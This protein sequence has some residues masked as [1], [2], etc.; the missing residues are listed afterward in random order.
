M[1]N[2][3]IDKIKYLL[4]AASSDSNRILNLIPT[5]NEWSK[6]LEN[7]RY[8]IMNSDGLALQEVG[9]QS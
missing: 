5:E 2:F 6:H 4:S 9:S 3:Q 7:F 8:G 1:I